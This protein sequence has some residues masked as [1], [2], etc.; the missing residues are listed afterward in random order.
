MKMFTFFS[1]LLKSLK[2]INGDKNK[3]FK[4]ILNGNSLLYTNYLTKTPVKIS[5]IDYLHHITA[6]SSAVTFNKRYKLISE[7]L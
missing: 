5:K 2:N 3:R 7:T 6:C 4:K 1:L